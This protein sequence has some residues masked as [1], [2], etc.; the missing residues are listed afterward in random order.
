MTF[1]IS[2]ALRILSI[3]LLGVV[4]FIS[5][6]GLPEQ[7]L[8]LLD[9]NSNPTQYLGKDTFFYSTLAFFIITNV[10]FY[11]LAVMSNKSVSINTQLVGKYLML[12]VIIVNIFFSVA[13]TFMAILNGQENF[14]Y[15]SFAPFIY[16]SLALFGFWGLAFM[17]SLLKIKKSV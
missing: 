8:V 15:S 1:K 12:L 5:Y 9:K 7:V 11:V 2:N 6:A 16:T 17:I 13:L 14:D 10:L 4:F 3:I